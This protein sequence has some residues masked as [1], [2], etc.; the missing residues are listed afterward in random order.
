[1]NNLAIQSVESNP[2]DM[3]Y[4]GCSV[5]LGKFYFSIEIRS[6]FTSFPLHS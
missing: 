3:Y 5:N 4:Q 2:I 6:A 1:M